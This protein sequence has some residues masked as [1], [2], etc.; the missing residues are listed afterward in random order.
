MDVVVQINWGIEELSLALNFEKK[1]YS[2]DFFEYKVSNG[3]KFYLFQQQKIGLQPHINLLVRQE[4][5]AVNIFA[6]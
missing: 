2:K 1:F 6:V 5:P 3:W 4:S